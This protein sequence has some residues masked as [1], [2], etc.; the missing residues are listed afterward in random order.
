MPANPRTSP[1]TPIS[2]TPM[3]TATRKPYVSI[4]HD[5]G[6]D[7]GMKAIMNVIASSPICRSDTP[8]SAAAGPVIGA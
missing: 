1:K 3:P 4:T 7:S 6:M 8:Y 5:A 2:A